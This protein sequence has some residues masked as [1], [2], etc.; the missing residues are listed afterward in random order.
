M[1]KNLNFQEYVEKHTPHDT[2][3]LIC[4]KCYERWIGVWPHTTWLK[5]MSCPY[6]KQ[7]GTIITTG[8]ILEEEDY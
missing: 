7:R 4:I 1:C 3:E 6:C 8:Q 2:A 5:D